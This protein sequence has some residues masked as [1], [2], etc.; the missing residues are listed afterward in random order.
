[1]LEFPIEVALVQLIDGEFMSIIIALGCVFSP[2]K[3]PYRWITVYAIPSND[4]VLTNHFASLRDRACDSYA[5]P[6]DESQ[7]CRLFSFVRATT[8]QRPVETVKVVVQ[9]QSASQEVNMRKFM[10]SNY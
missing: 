3:A 4:I 6:C 10:E 5:L 1:M 7:V 2:T 9:S 8:L